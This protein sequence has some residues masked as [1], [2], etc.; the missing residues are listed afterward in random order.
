MKN[1]QCPVSFALVLLA[2][3]CLSACAR[4]GDAAALEGRWKVRL[5]LTHTFLP[6]R[7]PL[8]REVEGE[9]IF[10]RRVPRLGWWARGD[11]VPAR[12]AAGCAF[13][14]DEAFQGVPRFPRH[15]S[16]DSARRCEHV[17][18]YRAGDSL[19]IVAGTGDIDVG[20]LLAGVRRGDTVSGAWERGLVSFERTHAGTFQMWR[21]GGAPPAGFF[22]LAR[23][24]RANRR[25]EYVYVCASLFFDSGDPYRQW[26]GGAAALLAAAAFAAVLWRTRRP[27]RRRG[28]ALLVLCAALVVELILYGHGG[29]LLHNMV[30]HAPGGPI[31]PARPILELVF[32]MLVLVP[33]AAA[34]VIRRVTRP[35]PA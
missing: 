16:P 22:R 8:A 15:A 35:R 2:A 33:L 21:A 1:A 3:A 7:P 18:A 29:D 19:H 26:V 28:R 34:L 6:Q 20:V 13:I 17:A 10:S 27:G 5:R 30:R 12:H 11:L 14:A 24:E 9:I 31:G 23:Q 32:A 25:R 4:E